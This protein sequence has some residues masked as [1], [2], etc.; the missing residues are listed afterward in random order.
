M[1][2]VV[3]VRRTI[4]VE[5]DVDREDYGSLTDDQVVACETLPM[6]ASG[7]PSIVDYDDGCVTSSSAEVTFR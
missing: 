4:V 1:S 6:G 7:G 5:Y 2:T 3:H